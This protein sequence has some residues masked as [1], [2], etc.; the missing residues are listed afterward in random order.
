MTPPFRFSLLALLTSASVSPIVY[1]ADNSKVEYQTVEVTGQSTQST[2]KTAAASDEQSITVDQVTPEQIQ[3]S[4]PQ[5]LSDAISL[6]PGIQ[7]SGN[8]SYSY[9]SRGFALTRDNVK[10]DGLNAWALKD[11]QIPMIA[12]ERV[13]VLK[14]VGSMLF[15]SQEVGGTINLVTKKPQKIRHT[16]VQI[17]GGS[18]LTPQTD[19]NFGTRSFAV[20]STGAVDE[21][22][23]WLYRFIADYRGQSGFEDDRDKHG[24]YLAPMLTWLP[25]NQQ[26]LTLQME[27]TRY[28]YNDLSGLVAPGS[29]IGQVDSATTNYYGGQNDATDQGVS[30]TLTYLRHLSEGW[31]LTS[32]WRS[33]WHRDERA[34]F[35]VGRVTSDSVFRR[36][37][38]IANHQLNHQLDTYV[39]GEFFTGSISHDLTVGG[40][41]AHTRN[42]FN[43][44]N[45]GGNDSALTVSVHNPVFTHID[46]STIS[47]GP[48][49]HRIYTYDTYSAYAQDIIGLTSKLYVQLG[50]RFDW[51]Q[52]DATYVSYTRSNGTY[53]P[54]SHEKATEQYWTPTL[55][56]S[57][58]LTPQW[59]WHGG[60]SRSYETSGVDSLDANGKPFDPEQGTQY[61][62]GIHYTP[63]AAWSG[64]LTLFHIEKQNVVVA[65]SRG[66]NAALGKIRS[67]GA[68]LSVHAQ[69]SL[70]STL[71]VSYTW[72]KTK[73]VEGDQDNPASSDEGNE[74]INAP[75][76]RLT[77][78]GYY[79]L[80]SN[81]QV[82]SIVTAQT[83]SYGSTDNDLV[84]PGY[85]TVDL[86]SRYRLTDHAA[87][88]VSIKNV[89]D[90]YYYRAAK[91]ANAIY[92]G[93]PR[94]LQAR[95]T[96]DF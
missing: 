63:H 7:S 24:Y 95:F 39:T 12:V 18:Y 13:D 38:H 73:V 52:R 20:D 2:T 4:Q 23:N 11:N 87:F 96:Y 62:T 89:L 34:S 15:G 40:G 45:W 79:Q 90:Q 41:Y 85:T 51:Q 49:T 83:H 8:N 36:Y 6:L 59:R 82:G 21:Q 35:S 5:E 54:G 47:N 19:Q 16:E 61:E 66:D 10:M 43:R 68:E 37:Q 58:L 32:R 76:Q 55:G 69:P 42:D 57:Y 86:T 78:Q 22:Q 48:G 31:E 53:V 3:L 94:Y 80:N 67:Q 46:T 14:G 27:M 17:E 29:D 26:S 56:V 60:Y 88:D 9:V 74:F 77:L 70:N 1:A 28:K 65:N 71:I 93:E 72:L 44:I 25:D 92:I 30:T 84:L 81:W 50:G 64:D 75:R 91:N 33:V